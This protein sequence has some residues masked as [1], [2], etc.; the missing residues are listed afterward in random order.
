MDIKHAF[1]VFHMFVNLSNGKNLKIL[2]IR[3]VQLF[4]KGNVLLR[5][6]LTYKLF[7]EMVLF[8]NKQLLTM[9]V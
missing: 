5:D 9:L 4:N 7:D 6:L 8:T 1:R 2:V 3:N